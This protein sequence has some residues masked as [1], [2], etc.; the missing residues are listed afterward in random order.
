MAITTIVTFIGYSARQNIEQE[1]ENVTVT[2]KIVLLVRDSLVESTSQ[3]IRSANPENHPDCEYSAV[4]NQEH[5]KGR[6]TKRKLKSKRNQNK[7]DI[8]KGYGSRE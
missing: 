7:S 3:I 2:T 4:N 6:L 8:L 5:S 1:R